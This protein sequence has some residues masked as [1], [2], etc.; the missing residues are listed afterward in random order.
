MMKI[1][2]L[3]SVPFLFCGL[4]LCTSCNTY[5]PSISRAHLKM[6]RLIDYSKFRKEIPLDSLKSLSSYAK[7]QGYVMPVLEYFFTIDTSGNVVN[8]NDKKKGDR[9]PVFF[10]SYIGNTF[11]NYKWFPAFYNGKKIERLNAVAKLTIWENYDTHFFEVIIRLSHL[12]E[13]EKGK[14]DDIMFDKNLIYR[15]KIR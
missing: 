5:K 9:S 1:I 11:N 13:K 10:K 6:P 4:F 8:G 2:K 15:F 7:S 3:L 14:M 12:P